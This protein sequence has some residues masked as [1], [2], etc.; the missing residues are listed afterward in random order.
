VEFNKIYELAPAFVRG[1]LHVDA[2]DPKY[3]NVSL[4]I[5]RGEFR[6]DEAV[7][8]R[9]D[10]GGRA[11]DFV[12]STAGHIIGSPKVIDI[13]KDNRFTGWTTYPVEIYN[14]QD[15]KLEGYAGL[16]IIGRCGYLDATNSKRVLVPLYPGV[17][18]SWQMQGLEFDPDSWDGS[19]LFCP[20]DVQPIILAV[21]KVVQALKKAKVTNMRAVA[22]SDYQFFEPERETAFIVEGRK[23]DL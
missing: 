16:A 2:A 17:Q 5:T 6:V 14:K 4:L 20:G 3:N 11:R 19:D 1:V 13:L 23:P 15:E 10:S 12:C 7:V 9:H 8:F 18:P 21:D 22:L